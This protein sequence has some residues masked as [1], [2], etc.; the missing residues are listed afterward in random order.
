MIANDRISLRPVRDEDWGAIERWGSDREG[1]W[2]PYQRFQLDHLPRLRESYDRTRLL[3]RESALLLVEPREGG[4]PVGFV[5]Y[6]MQGFP[7]EDCPYPDIGVGIAPEARGKGYATEAIRLLVGY[8]FDGYP[9][10]R[11]AATTD[12]ENAPAQRAMERLGFV[13]EGILR[14]VS[15]RDG[16]WVDMCVYAVLRDAWQARS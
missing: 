10:E 3:S 12:V 11:I 15:F 14:R 7:D 8:L 13:R 9:V 16:R 5:R 6:A 4:G 1:L 2:G